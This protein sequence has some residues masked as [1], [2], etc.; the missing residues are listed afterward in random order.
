MPP[1]SKT[2]MLWHGI[3]TVLVV[4]ICQLF[5][6]SSLQFLNLHNIKSLRRL[7]AV[8]AVFAGYVAYRL[9]QKVIDKFLLVT[10]GLKRVR[11]LDE[12]FL[13]ERKGV[14]NTTGGVMEF[15]RFKFEDF[16][17]WTKDVFAEKF[18][19]GKCRLRQVM[20]NFYHERMT[21]EEFDA[22]F[23]Q[24]VWKV[25]EEVHDLDALGKVVTREWNR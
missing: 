18:P 21:D 24:M 10:M 1:L 2:T 20:G 5:K 22:K 9:I 6:R 15:D 13:F 17:K 7:V 12:F 23:D 3:R 11:P 19:T 8:I 4:K 14:P 25:E 16:K